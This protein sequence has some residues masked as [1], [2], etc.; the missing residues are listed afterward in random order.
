[1]IIIEDIWTVLTLYKTVYCVVVLFIKKILVRV[2]ELIVT[3]FC[4]P[5]GIEE[6]KSHIIHLQV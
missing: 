3:G 2:T 6:G 1:M 4:Y 5:Q